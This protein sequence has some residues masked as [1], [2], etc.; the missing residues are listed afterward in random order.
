[1]TYRNDQNNSEKYYLWDESDRLRVAVDKQL[2]HYIYDAGGQRVL[3]ASSSMEALYE[4]GQLVDTSIQMGNYTSYPSAF[5]VVDPDG[6]YSKHYYAGGQRIA[7]RVGQDHADSLFPEDS[8][9]SCFE[10]LKGRSVSEHKLLQ[11]TDL[12]IYL[13]QGGIKG[14]LRFKNYIPN[15][16]KEAESNDTTASEAE[17]TYVARAEDQIYYYHPDHLGTGTFLTDIN[18]LPYEFFLNLPFGETMAEQH[19]QTADYENRWKFTGHELDK[20]TGLYYAGAR[21][22]DP[23]IS[24]W[25]SVDPMTEQDPGWTPYRYCYQNPINII[26]PDGM[27]EYTYDTEGNV[28]LAKETKDKFDMIYSLE[29][30]NGDKKN[31]L[32]INN[33]NIL[34]GLLL[35]RDNIKAQHHSDKNTILTGIYTTSNS[36]AELL[37]LFEF[38]SQNADAEWTLQGNG[39]KDNMIVALGRYTGG[40]NKNGKWIPSTDQA[41]KFEGVLD[42]FNDNNLVFHYHNHSGETSNDFNPSPNDSMNALRRLKHSPNA[43]ISIYMPK[44][45]KDKYNKVRPA[46]RPAINYEPSKYL[47]LDKN[48]LKYIK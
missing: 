33:T 38:F 35:K 19:S 2:H 48:Y 13:E 34:S 43:D 3:K 8:G 21:Y 36:K 11:Q 23:K 15:S 6:V 16:E 14:Q 40:F 1:M 44:I 12:K 32:K 25:L 5:L 39:S 47:R 20:E 9:S 45:T 42:G 31:G 10:K 37:K 7:A 26:D 27:H 29:D 30:Y 22:Y 41:I 4:N 24:I 17:S 46:G 28:K 18:G